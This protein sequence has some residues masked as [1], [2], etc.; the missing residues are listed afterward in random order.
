MCVEQSLELAICGFYYCVCWTCAFVA[1]AA[2]AKAGD[3]GDN[4]GVVVSRKRWRLSSPPLFGGTRRD[5]EQRATCDN[6]RRSACAD[7]RVPEMVAIIYE[8][9]FV[10]DINAPATLV[11][12][13]RCRRFSRFVRRLLIRSERA[14]ACA[15]GRRLPP[16]SQ[17]ATT[18]TT[19]ARSIAT[20]VDGGGGGDGGGDVYSGGGGR[21]QLCVVVAVMQTL[22][23][24][25]DAQVAR[26]RA[27][28][29]DR[30]P[31]GTQMQVCKSPLSSPIFTRCCA[32]R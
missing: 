22:K 2:A 10:T 13:C 18:T 25:Y 20:L 11:Y 8:H 30:A 14:R 24:I 9:R 31:I 3:A 7:I 4:G 16:P 17:P 26:I 1:T 19:S 28:D 21:S 15:R 6:G 23:R 5:D 27:R 12:F 32:R 29:F